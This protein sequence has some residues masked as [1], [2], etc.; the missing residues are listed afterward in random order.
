MPPPTTASPP[1]APPAA[2]A[3]SSLANDF[4]ELRQC[5][6]GDN[7][8]IDTGNG[9]YGAYQFAE[10]TWLSLGYTG[11]PNQA[12]PAVQD[13]AAERLQAEDG[14]APWPACSALLGL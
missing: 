4:A 14:W 10:S 8:Q 12:P 6:S 13:Q 2:P 11:F 5:E 9:F 7:Y 1:P 3:T